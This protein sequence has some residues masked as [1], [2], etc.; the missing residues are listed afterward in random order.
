MS[1]PSKIPPTSLV[2]PPPECIHHKYEH[3]YKYATHI[4]PFICHMNMHIP[5]TQKQAYTKYRKVYMCTHIHTIHTCKHTNINQ[6]FNTVFKKKKQRNSAQFP[7]LNFFLTLRIILKFHINILRGTE[8]SGILCMNLFT[9]NARDFSGGFL[10][11]FVLFL[12]DF[13]LFCFCCCC[14]LFCF[15]LFF[16]CLQNFSTENPLMCQNYLQFHDP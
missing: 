14:F 12:F 9:M 2:P 15:F 1:Y 5:Q 6:K 7:S 3:K 10:F 8:C 13:V 4:H 11:C 16:I